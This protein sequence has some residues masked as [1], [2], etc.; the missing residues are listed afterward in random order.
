ME[1]RKVAWYQPG[2]TEAEMMMEGVFRPLFSMGFAVAGVGSPVTSFLSSSDLF[3]PVWA[4]FSLR[5]HVPFGWL[6]QKFVTVCQALFCIR[7]TD[8]WE[9]HTVHESHSA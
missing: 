2:R 3:R 5:V 7:V 8:S 9:Q 6:L 1:L 4:G